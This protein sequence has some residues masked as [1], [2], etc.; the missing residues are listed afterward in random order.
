[1]KERSTLKCA[2]YLVLEQDGQVLL[3]KRKGSG[4]YDGFYSLPAGHW[5]KGEF[6]KQTII[7]EAK[8]EAN[9]DILG[10]DLE[11]KMTCSSGGDSY[12]GLYFVATKYSGQVNNNEPDKCDDLRFFPYDAL[13]QE[14]VPY[15]SLVLEAIKKGQNYLE[16][17]IES[18]EAL[19]K[20]TQTHENKSS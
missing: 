14:T 12:I 13:P 18:P 11:L 6:C 3:H 19:K 15:I 10:D 8:E 4:F 16:I 20:R 7:R 17:E 2:V 9:V 1:M 5:E